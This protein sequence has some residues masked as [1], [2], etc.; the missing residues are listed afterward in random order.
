MGRD[1][2]SRRSVKGLHGNLSVVVVFEA[3][4]VNVWSA[5]SVQSG[6]KAGRGPSPERTRSGSEILDLSLSPFA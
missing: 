1:Y 5:T 4:E 2:P 6:E 3:H